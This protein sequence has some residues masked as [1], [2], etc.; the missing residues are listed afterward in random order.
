MQVGQDGGVEKR[1]EREEELAEETGNRQLED[2]ITQ[3]T[4]MY[5]ASVRSLDR[6]VELK[7]AFHAVG[8]YRDRDVRW[9]Y[10]LRT[11][12]MRPLFAL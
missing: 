6:Q 5:M 3:Y 9:W 2:T 1:S 4:V 7:N 12:V 8:V 11:L 10:L